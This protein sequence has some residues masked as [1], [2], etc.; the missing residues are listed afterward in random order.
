MMLQQ[1][2]SDKEEVG[3][4]DLRDRVTLASTQYHV[5]TACSSD[6]PTERPDPR[7]IL[8]H[9]S[10]DSVPIVPVICKGR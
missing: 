6:L 4:N 2:A 3:S 8:E 1:A 5:T 7:E 10:S 9:R